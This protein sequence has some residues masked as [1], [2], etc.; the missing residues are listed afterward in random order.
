[1][2][3]EILTAKIHN[4]ANFH[5]LHFSGKNRTCVIHLHPQLDASRIALNLH[6]VS[7]VAYW[8][9]VGE[10]EAQSH[11]EETHPM[12][13][14]LDHG[15]GIPSRATAGGPHLDINYCYTTI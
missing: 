14:S 3:R 6:Q 5:C 12:Y 9:E 13:N 11:V 2:A 1:M 7:K 15:H 4:Y 10:E 8:A